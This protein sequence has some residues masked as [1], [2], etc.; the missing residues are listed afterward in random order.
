MDGIQSLI[1]RLGIR[2][3]IYIL[4]PLAIMGIRMAWRFFKQLNSDDW[5]AIQ[6][7]CTFAGVTH[8]ENRYELKLLY[9]YK[10]ATEKYA[11]GGE[12]YKDFFKEEQANRWAEALRE[13][14]IPIH[15]HPSKPEKSILWD[16]DLEFIVKS[17]K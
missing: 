16:S 10:L 4:V 9:S 12:F 7:K 1:T 5:P 11:T 3:A 15:H 8:K 2:T 13:K 6:G 14:S 17:F